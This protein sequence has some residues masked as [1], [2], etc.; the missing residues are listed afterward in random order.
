MNSSFVVLH[1]EELERLQEC[2]SFR[3][4]CKELYIALKTKACFNRWVVGGKDPKHAIG[5]DWIVDTLRI[6]YQLGRN[7][8]KPPQ[9]TK[10]QARLIIDQLIAV[11][12]LE[13]REL[14]RNRSGFVQIMFFFLP[15]AF[16]C[17]REERHGSVT[18]TSLKA[19]SPISPVR[20]YIPE[21]LKGKCAPNEGHASVTKEKLD[22]RHK[23]NDSIIQK[24]ED[25]DRAND[26]KNICLFKTLELTSSGEI[27]GLTP[28][29]KASWA[30]SYPLFENLDHVLTQL[31]KKFARS[32]AVI[33]NV[34]NYIERCL[35]NEHKALLNG[36]PSNG[37]L[38]QRPAQIPANQER[39]PTEAPNPAGKQNGGGGHGSTPEPKRDVR[40][41]QIRDIIRRNR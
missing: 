23:S 26:Q 17:V 38:E 39:A 7:T 21:A 4:E 12:L 33:R 2:G 30:E 6:D 16:F 10:R 36:G 28:E 14:P 19:T 11:G 41:D 9:I 1:A 37:T 27:L 13:R 5:L 3:R 40:Y 20:Q 15:I 8:P 25:D 22:E 35:E 18:G 24:E 31:G 32:G 34:K 29:L